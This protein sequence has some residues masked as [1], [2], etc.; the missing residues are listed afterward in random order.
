MKSILRKLTCVALSGAMLFATLPTL[1]TVA[2]EETIPT[3]TLDPSDAMQQSYTN[4]SDAYVQGNTPEGNIVGEIAITVHDHP[5]HV[6]IQYESSE[7]CLTFYETD[8]E[9]L[10]DTTATEYIFP[11]F[12]CETPNDLT[13]ANKT[14]TADFLDSTYAAAYTLTITVPTCSAKATY[15]ESDI[16]IADYHQESEITGTTRYQ[17]DVTFTEDYETRPQ[18]DATEYDAVIEDG[19]VTLDRAVELL[20]RPFELGDVDGNGTVNPV[21]A[22]NILI[23]YCNE[24]TGY[25]QDPFFIDEAADVDYDGAINPID[26]MYVLIF[27][28]YKNVGDGTGYSMEEIVSNAYLN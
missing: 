11:L 25:D 1:A 3:V 10:E 14:Y 6:A 12:Y 21:D 26:A 18:C 8:L 15:T 16:L 7:S 28:A 22:Y 27:Y 17:Y 13:H 19:C 20:W 24:N 4:R 9:P 5:I 23:Y 2:E